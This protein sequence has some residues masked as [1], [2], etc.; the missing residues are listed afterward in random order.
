[1]KY[2]MNSMKRLLCLVCCFCWLS[3]IV[4]GSKKTSSFYLAEL[5]CENLIEPLGIDNVTPHFSWKLKGDGWKGGQTYYE[6]QVASDSILLV[7]DKADLWNTGKLKSDVSVMVPYQGKALTSRSLCYWRVRVWDAKKQVSSWSPV[8]RFGVG[9]LN[10]SQMQGEYIGASAKGGKICAPIL[11]KKVKL[12]PGETSFLHVNTLG[13]HEIYVNGKKVGEDV[14]T[15]AVSHLSKRSLIVTYD[16]TPYL[17]GGENDLLI[18]LGQGWYKTTTFGAA[19]EGPLVKAELDV[20]RNGK[21]EVITKTDGSW[22]GR[23]SGHS[24]TGTWRALQFGGERVDGRILPRDL[25][26]QALDKMKWTPVVKVNVPEHITSPQMCE[27]NKIHQILQAVSV[28]KLGESLWLVDMGKVQT[29]WFEMQMP[30]L[31]TGH[32]VIMEYSDNLTKDGE[33]DK[34]GESDIYI[35]G[36]KQGE[37]FRNKFN[38]H[39]FRYVRISN[40]PQK[41]AAD[42]MKSLQ[43]YGD[44]K[45]TATFECSD[46]DLNAIHNMVQYTMK[47]LTFSGY[48]VDCPHLERAGYGGDGNS[49]TMSLQTMYD[50][51]PTFANWVQT[52][53]DSMREGGSLPHVGPNPGAGGGGPYWCGFFVQAPWRTYVNYSDSRL[54][55]K[56]YSQMKEWFKYVDKYTVDGLLKRWPDTKYRD[57]YLGDWLAPMGVDAG[58]QASVD[59]VSNCFISECL[60]T[61]YKTA[62]TLGKKEEAEEFA[63][64]REKLNKLIHQTFYRADEGIYS[65]G[66]QLDMC[67]P[68]LVGVVP[69]SLYNKV[70]E[71]VVTMTEE[72]HKGHIAVGLV[73]VPILTEWSVR[74]KQVD[75]F[76]QMM[77]KRDYPGYLYMIDHGA[78]ATWEYWSGERSRVHNCYNGIGTW[79]YQAVGGIRLDEAE[80]GYRHFYVDP[81]IPNGVT[82]AKVT[83]ESPYGTIAVNWELQGNQLNLQLTVPAGTTA[84]VCIP[85]NAVSYKMNKKKVSIKKQ[86]VDVEAGHYDF[87]FNL[88]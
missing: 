21:W 74:N 32:E 66:S 64:R 24:D 46:A 71:N 26:T 1:M 60:G 35:S 69:D 79:F 10:K 18:W 43:I 29:G 63:I 72:K 54:I 20:L 86:T 49:S 9:I 30:I 50:V 39:A 62:L 77:K 2:D 14:L 76:Y 17:R 34:Q 12:T 11:R 81:Q 61:M 40:L 80:P 56:Y 51:A 58:N 28:K 87:L 53:G 73:G 8:V 16:I 36:G 55:E 65:T 82:W 19:Y 4:Y 67:Y 23:E 75:F 47:C 84:T 7:Q 5:K 37:Y 42:G 52:W 85:N 70:K 83:K 27:M 31:P 45:Q 57:W 44:Y 59:L 48:M 15:P 6:I 38:H 22:Y 13:Y 41:P 68:M 78:T 33:F 88:K 25:S 3:V